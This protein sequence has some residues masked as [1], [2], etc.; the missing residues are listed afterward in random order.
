M[1]PWNVRINTDFTQ[2]QS[3]LNFYLW[4]LAVHVLSITHL[5]VAHRCIR[6]YTFTALKKRQ[7]SPDWVTLPASSC[8]RRQDSNKQILLTS[9]SDEPHILPSKV[10]GTSRQLTNALKYRG[11]RYARLLSTKVVMALNYYPMKKRASYWR[12]TKGSQTGEK[13]SEI[14]CWQQRYWIGCYITQ[15]R[16]ISKESTG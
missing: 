12:Q 5:P 6:I 1:E 2:H 8:N 13:C 9:S 10:N 4:R 15:P 11:S 14:T 3:W 16:W 7:N